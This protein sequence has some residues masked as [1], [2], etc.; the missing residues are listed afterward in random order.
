VINNRS[1]SNFIFMGYCKEESDKG[2]EGEFS[3]SLF[4]E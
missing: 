2:G 3:L 4:C 1:K